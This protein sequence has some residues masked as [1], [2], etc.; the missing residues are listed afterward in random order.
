MDNNVYQQ[1]D[2]QDIPNQNENDEL[3]NNNNVLY[4]REE[5]NYSLKYTKITTSFTIIFLL[6]II[7]YIYFHF[8]KN[9]DKFLFE[10]Y[11]IINYNQFYRCITRYFISYGFCHLAFELYLTYIVFNIYNVL[12]L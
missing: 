5:L 11:L 7:Y 6:K 9:A 2:N 12:L 8:S 10:Y 3:L 4:I 1:E